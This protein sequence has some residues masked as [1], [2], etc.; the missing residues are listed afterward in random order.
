MKRIPRAGH[1]GK[2]QASELK[3]ERLTSE[4]LVGKK[5]KQLYEQYNLRD[6]LYW[7]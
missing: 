7:V 2:Y 5:P 1:A 4:W 6:T 3:P